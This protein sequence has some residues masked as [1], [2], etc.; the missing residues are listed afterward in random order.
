MGYVKESV[1]QNI[2]GPVNFVNL[3]FSTKANFIENRITKRKCFS[4]EFLQ[5]R[6]AQYE[7]SGAAT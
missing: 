5:V 2:S 6:L 7:Y 4:H 3:G 1:Q